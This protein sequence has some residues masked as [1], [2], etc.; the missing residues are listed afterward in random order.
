VWSSTGKPRRHRVVG[1]GFSWRC[2][3]SNTVSKQ[4]NTRERETGVE[5][6]RPSFVPSASSAGASPSAIASVTESGSAGAPSPP[7]AVA[8]TSSLSPPSCPCSSLLSVVA[9]AG[10]ASV[11]PSL[12]PAL[13]SGSMAGGGTGTSVDSVGSV[14]Y[15]PPAHTRKGVSCGRRSNPERQC[16]EEDMVS[17]NIGDDGCCQGENTSH[18]TDALAP[19]PSAPIFT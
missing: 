17:S 6:Y 8:A 9:M 7:S 19:R 10:P 12:G 1:S 16:G 3:C 5:M 11:P 14:A 13:S 4:Y 2:G 18:H 15:V